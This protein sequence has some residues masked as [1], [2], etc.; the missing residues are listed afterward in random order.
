MCLSVSV[1]VW[2]CV[3]VCVCV[4]L[5]VGVCACVCA[6]VCMCARVCVCV[7]VCVH[8]YCVCVSVCVCVHVCTVCCL[9]IVSGVYPPVNSPARVWT[10]LQNPHTNP[11]PLIPTGNVVWHS[12]Q[13]PHVLFIIMRQWSKENSSYGTRIRSMYGIPKTSLPHYNKENMRRPWRLADNVTGSY[14]YFSHI[15]SRTDATQAK[16][17]YPYVTIDHLPT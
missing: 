3:C 6:C 15:L 11:T 5:C 4:S 8:V 10:G 14:Q 17:F 12:S 13:H 16:L 1:C 2:V 7:Y 9:Y